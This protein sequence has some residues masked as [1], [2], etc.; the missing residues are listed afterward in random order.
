ME[1]EIE[2]I[3]WWIDWWRDNSNWFC[4]VV[5]TGNKKYYIERDLNKD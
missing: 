5:K 2:I 1:L 4:A 3:D